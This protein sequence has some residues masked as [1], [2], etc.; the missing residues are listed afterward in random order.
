MTRSHKLVVST[1]RA[2]TS[3]SAN[4]E[5]RLTRFLRLASW[6]PTLAGCAFV[7]V[8]LDRWTS[9]TSAL[10]WDADAAAA[11]LIAEQFGRPG[12]G[13]ITIAHFG[14]YSMLWVMAGTR[15]L[16]GHWELWQ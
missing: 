11:P 10:M 14:W 16:S 15:D 3:T 8:L 1:E 6:A 12:T 2:S 4:E 9:I 7:V 13:V 5:K